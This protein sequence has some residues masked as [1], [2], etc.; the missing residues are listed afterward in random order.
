[1]IQLSTE[2]QKKDKWKITDLVTWFTYIGYV[3][4]G[5]KLLYI[6][7]NACIWNVCVLRIVLLMKIRILNVL[8]VINILIHLLLCPW[9]I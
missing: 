2:I 6:Y 4:L 8:Y 5:H 7:K 9:F 3:C 1:M